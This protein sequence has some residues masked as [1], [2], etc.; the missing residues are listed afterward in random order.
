MKKNNLLF[1]LGTRPEA[2]KL[3]P[4]ILKFKKY[5]IFN[6][7]VC[8]TGQHREML[9]EIFESF[10]IKL[11]YDLSIMIE[12]QDLFDIST[13]ILK[14]IKLIFSKSSADYVFVHGDTSSSQIVSLAAFYSKIPLIHIEAGLRTNILTSPWPEEGN[15]QLISRLAYL[16]YAPTE[17]A[18]D[19][20]IKENIDKNII[21]IT[22]NTV[23]DALSFVK[24]NYFLKNQNIINIEKRIKEKGFDFKLERNRKSIL[25]TGHRRENFGEALKNICFAINTL[26][27]NNP[28]INFIYPVHLNPNI[29]KPVF[30]L[31]DNKNKN[32]F[33]LEPLDYVSFLYLLKNCFIV[34]T[35]SGGIQEEA[36]SFNKPL[37]IMR[38]HTERQEVLHVGAA[39]LIGSKSENIIE[40]IQLLIEDENLYIE[41]SNAKNPFGD[42]K[43]CERI[44]EHFLKF[45]SK[46]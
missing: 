27:Q 7:L 3:A 2:I 20:L 5:N 41:M 31:I 46:V 39:K 26:A 40:Q 15:R 9:D 43:A 11:D 42:G 1:I 44:V 30:D 6:V 16:H 45:T 29:K 19:N 35:D 38:E 17:S 25:I 23:V 34:L 21:C 12:N 10:K 18:R 14:V 28:D 13:N 32:I 36:P 37:L 24:L 22:G 4:L 33:L 8:S